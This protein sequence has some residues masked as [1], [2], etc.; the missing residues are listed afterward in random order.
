MTIS[1][2]R[3]SR[4]FAALSL[5]SAALLALS[6]CNNTIKANVDNHSVK[7]PTA[8][9]MPAVQA[10]VGDYASEDYANRTQG[11]DWVGVMIR[12]EGNEQIDIKVR[13]RSDIKKPTCQ[14]DGKATL[15]G[16]DEA[17]GVFFQTK[18]DDSAVFFQFK[19]NK[20]TIDSQDRYV[21]NR[22]CSGGGTIVGEYKKLAGD[23][24]LK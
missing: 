23:L 8:T 14:F 19:G 10:V 24:E 16:Q 12:A 15:M 21:L 3:Y 5:T 6:G 22:F 18:V 2:S 17:H 7:Q 4:F 1:F 13:A 9:I 20:L 11:Y